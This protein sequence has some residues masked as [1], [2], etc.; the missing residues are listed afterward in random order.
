MTRN[1]PALPQE[2]VRRLQELRE[3][4]SLPALRARVAVL[5]EAGWSLAAVG[6][7]LGANRST[8]RMW[9]LGAV[10]E[11][12]ET[13]RQANPAPRLPRRAPAPVARLFPD[14]PL[15]ERDELIRLAES[16][17]QVRGWTPQ[18][19]KTRTDKAEFERRLREYVSRGVP[20]KRLADHIGVTHRAIAARLEREVAS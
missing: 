4:G 17:R 1:L 2:E 10:A 16:A 18:D 12:V 19:A 8:T 11:D 7:P 9:Q 20:L 5:R 13:S 3:S 14:V 6:A 15:D